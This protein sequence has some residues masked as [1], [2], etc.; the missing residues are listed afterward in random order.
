[1]PVH[2]TNRGVALLGDKLYL[3]TLDAHLVALD[4]KTGKLV[5]DK[6]LANW[7]E[8]YYSTLAP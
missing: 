5:W 8:G 1:M 7:E 6:T 4:A 2:P 3:A